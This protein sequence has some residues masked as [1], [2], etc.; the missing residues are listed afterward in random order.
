MSKSLSVFP[1]RVRSDEP[2]VVPFPM[3]NSVKARVTLTKKLQEISKTS[4]TEKSTEVKDTLHSPRQRAVLPSLI[5]F[6]DKDLGTPHHNKKFDLSLATPNSSKISQPT[7]KNRSEKKFSMWESLTELKQSLMKYKTAFEDILYPTKSDLKKIIKCLEL[8]NEYSN[9]G[10]VSLNE[11]MQLII[12]ILKMA[13]YVN[14]R[15]MRSYANDIENTGNEELK[16]IL[17]L[18]GSDDIPYYYLSTGLLKEIAKKE[19]ELDEN[20]LPKSPFEMK[21]QEFSKSIQEKDAEIAKL[22]EILTTAVTKEAADYKDSVIDNLSKQLDEYKQEVDALNSHIQDLTEEN[23]LEKARFEQELQEGKEAQKMVKFL[24][25][26]NK[27]I[28]EMT[29]DSRN[30]IKDM[31]MKMKSFKDILDKVIIKIGIIRQ[32]VYELK[33]TNEDLIYEN[34]RLSLRAAVGFESLTPRAN[35]KK[36]ADDSGI[37]LGITD[38]EGKKQIVSTIRIV[39]HLVKTVSDLKDKISSA[40]ANAE[41]SKSS[42]NEPRR[43]SVY[44]AKKPADLTVAKPRSSFSN[45][46]PTRKKSAYD[47]LR[48]EKPDDDRTDSEDNLSPLSINNAKDSPNES[49]RI[50]IP[51][52]KIESSFG[53]N[54]LKQ[55]EELIDSIVDTKQQL[56]QL[57]SDDLS[58]DSDRKY[59]ILSS[60]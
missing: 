19:F 20:S 40:A 45:Q 57:Q 52:I 34:E 13:L 39:E 5:N 54:V 30:K 12:R 27:R 55:S 11:L 50:Q 17:G 26:D 49:R 58:I 25:D 41:K 28:M 21:I 22:N 59:S 53:Q 46:V 14:P 43:K 2:H 8:L 51:K 29:E 37:E 48:I 3:A 32:E 31:Q 1:P 35:Y 44:T 16:R 15:I 23:A 24:E 38:A 60:H 6:F 33:K 36:I 7:F 4:Y 18:C 9:G 47:N 10:D 42:Q 56:D